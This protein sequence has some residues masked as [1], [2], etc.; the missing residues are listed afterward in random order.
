MVS[1][2]YLLPL[3]LHKFIK[4]E[5]TNMLE[6]GLIEHAALI[7]VVLYKAPAGSSLTETKRLVIDY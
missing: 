4:E 2:S 5:P 3:K 1:K 7:M 6:A